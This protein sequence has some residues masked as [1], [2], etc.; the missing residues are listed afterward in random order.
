MRRTPPLRSARSVG[1]CGGRIPAFRSV[2]APFCSSGE[3]PSVT[4]LCLFSRCEASRSVADVVPA[5]PSEA[6][7]DPLRGYRFRSLGDGAFRCRRRLIQRPDLRMRFQ[8]MGWWQGIRS[9]YSVVYDPASCWNRTTN[10]RNC[11][12]RSGMAATSFSD[13]FSRSRLFISRSNVAFNSVDAR[14]NS[15]IAFP[16]VLPSSGNFFGPNS[17]NARMKM[18]TVSC[19]PRGPISV[20]FLQ[21]NSNQL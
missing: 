10:S 20:H 17:S 16:S 9:D 13:S 8:L 6:E 2:R 12:C 4:T 19:Q 21:Q 3:E 1:L 11:R 14:R 18:N 15:V 5:A 7:V